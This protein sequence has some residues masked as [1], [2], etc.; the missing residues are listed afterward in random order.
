MSV[1]PALAGGRQESFLAG[2]MAGVRFVFSRQAILAALSLDM[3][4]V[5]F[6]GATALLPI[7]AEM[8]QAGSAGLGLLRAAPAVGALGIALMQSHR[9]PFRKTGQAM[10]ISVWLFGLSMI[11]FPL[12][13][14]FWVSFFLL[15]LGGAADNVSVVVRASILQAMTPDPLRGRVSSINGFFISSS[16]EIGAFES[17]VAAKLLGV[18]PSVVLGGLLTWVCVGVAAWKAPALRRLQLG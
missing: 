16:N 17:G 13:R 4:A 5:L 9:P 3:F 18:V 12:S 10:L 2:F 8:L 14:W 15:A 6:G 11:L 7:F 1:R